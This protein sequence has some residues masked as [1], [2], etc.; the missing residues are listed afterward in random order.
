MFSF[1]ETLSTAVKIVALE[2]RV[3]IELWYNEI[4]RTNLIF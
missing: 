4:L 3:E 1:D 2:V